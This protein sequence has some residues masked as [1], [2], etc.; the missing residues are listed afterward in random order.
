MRGGGRIS[1]RVMQR[2][3]GSELLGNYDGVGLKG[4]SFDGG[5][6][7]GEEKID[8]SEYECMDGP[9]TMYARWIICCNV[10]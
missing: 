10:T 2:G 5:V 1:G 4:W 9:E 7:L 6:V 8:K 3:W